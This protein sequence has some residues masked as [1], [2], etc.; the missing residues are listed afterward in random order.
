[1]PNLPHSFPSL[2]GGQSPGLVLG[3]G[4]SVGVSYLPSDLLAFVKSNRAAIEASLGCD[5]VQPLTS[6]PELYSWAQDILNQ[7]RPRGGLPNLDLA[8]ALGLTTDPK[9]RGEVSLRGTTPRHRVISRLAREGRWSAIWSLNWDSALECAF[10]RVGLEPGPANPAI[11]WPSGYVVYTSPQNFRPPTAP[12]TTLVLYKPHGC[13]GEIVKAHTERVSGAAVTDPEFKIGS[14][15]LA[16]LAANL[17]SFVHICSIFTNR[18]LVTLGWSGSEPYMIQAL[19]QV[20]IA[21]GLMSFAATADALSIIDLALN[22]AGH[23][24]IVGLYGATAAQALVEVRASGDYTADDLFLWIQAC[25]ALERVRQFCNVAD[26]PAVDAAIAAFR[27]RPNLT[28]FCVSWIDDFLPVWIRT[29][30]RAG[31]VRY[32]HNGV[33]V[34]PHLIP[35]DLRDE[36]VPIQ[37][38]GIDRPDLL[39]AAALLAALSPN[40]KGWDFRSCPGSLWRSSDGHLVV[41]VPAWTANMSSLDLRALKPMFEF[42]GRRIMPSV[43]RVSVLPLGALAGHPDV[44]EVNIL[45]GLVARQLIHI[46]IA[47]A[48]AIDAITLAEL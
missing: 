39:T 12:G 33:T 44:A 34:A 11:P 40:G 18:P 26:R 7:L 29:C 47:R 4:A 41:P 21:A 10:K 30:W 15:D 22:S 32:V 6:V 27:P 38:P 42:E 9:W 2:R 48:S 35:C 45:K 46:G 13:I 14:T 19:D 1:M 16:S 23:S 20:R 25:Y 24:Q 28:H 31:L 37:L 5:S 43:R 36:H 3:A 17:A 8:N